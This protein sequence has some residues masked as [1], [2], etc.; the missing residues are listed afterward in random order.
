MLLLPL[1]LRSKQARRQALLGKPKE[2]IDQT[3]LCNYHPMRTLKS[4]LLLRKKAKLQL[5][6]PFSTGHTQP[7]F[8]QHFPC[9]DVIFV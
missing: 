2:A 3:R 7:V 5:A 9:L 1:V 4:K 6:W 8:Q